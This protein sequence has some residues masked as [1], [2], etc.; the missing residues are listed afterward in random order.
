MM[1]E[2]GWSRGQCLSFRTEGE[3]S[4]KDIGLEHHIHKRTF[5]RFLSRKLL[6]NDK[7]ERNPRGG[8]GGNLITAILFLIPRTDTCALSP[9]GRE[10]G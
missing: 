8:E 10:P 4:E 1:S 9:T 2:D 3:K 7:K 5:P 6:Q